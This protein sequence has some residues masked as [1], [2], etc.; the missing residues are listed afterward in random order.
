MSEIE[1]QPP[2]PGAPPTRFVGGTLWMLALRWMIRIL[3]LVSMVILARLL[4]PGDFGLVAMAMVVYALIDSMAT[5]GVDL[6][7]IRDQ[8]DSLEL[9][10]GAW[11]IQVLQGIFIAILMLASIPFA[12]AYFEESRLQTILSL[13][14][15][16]ALIQGFRNIGTVA[17]RKELDFA[18]DFRF[19]VY[20]KLGVFA[21]TVTL[22]LWL[23]DYRAMVFG[24]LSQSVFE[25]VLSY[26]MHP[27]RSR[28]STRGIKE[29]WGF[30]QWLLISRIGMVLNEKSGQ[31]IV[32]RAFGTGVLGIYYVGV[33]IG[34]IFVY[35]VIMPMRRALFP[36]LSR[37]Q[38]QPDFT[39]RALE[40]IGLLV[41]ACVPVGVGL[42]VTST[43]IVSLI[44][45]E[46]WS[47]AAP[48]L[49][50]MAIFGTIAGI[51]LTLDLILLV[52]NRADFSARKAWMELVLLIPALVY[53]SGHGDIELVA[54][55]RVL[56][57]A[58]FVPLMIYYT[59]SVLRVSVWALY[60][61]IWRPLLA[62][63]IMVLVDVV[64]IEPMHLSLLPALVAKVLLA[65][66]TYVASLMGLWLLSGKAGGP[67]QVCVD[68]LR[69]RLAGGTPGS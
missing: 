14:A 62:G 51:N 4:T 15:L 33:E 8:R 67:E 38:D 27:H 49:S 55:A 58:V 54:S 22:A 17:F 16:S 26:R 32:G 35:E 56:V 64:V 63:L 53:A 60:G 7:L 45:G 28:I 69:Q 2:V 57:A 41:I 46:R 68:Y 36:N 3:G 23:R 61:V 40:V 24:M 31:L 18:K 25:L 47:E 12:V 9:Y 11:T 6:A 30:S 59:A 50:W 52:K 21:V 13:L 65:G 43:Q 29:L 19:A 5:T 42:H 10:D 1:V 44:F 34:T 39:Q 20:Q 48:V 37:L 66:S